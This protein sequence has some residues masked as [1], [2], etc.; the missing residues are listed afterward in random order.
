MLQ[1]RLVRNLAA[2]R[3]PRISLMGAEEQRQG[4]EDDSL[5]P[6]NVGKPQR[7]PPVS[8]GHTGQWAKRR[9]TRVGRGSD[10]PEGQDGRSF[11][12]GTS[13]EGRKLMP[14]PHSRATVDL[15]QRWEYG[16]HF[17]GLVLTL[18]RVPALRS[19]SPSQVRF[20]PPRKERGYFTPREYVTRPVNPH[21]PKGIRLFRIA[22][23]AAA[24]ICL[25]ITS[26]G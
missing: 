26:L 22:A 12:Q 2:L 4:G 19:A 23:P 21:I 9:T 11:F 24:E 8:L 13:K 1:T 20:S 6:G 10:R 3:L 7:S 14:D 16:I 15:V 5:S 18:Y 17:N 25:A